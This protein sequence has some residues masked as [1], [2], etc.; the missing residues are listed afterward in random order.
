MRILFIDD[1]AE[2]VMSLIDC[3]EAKGVD[4]IGAINY[5]D[6]IKQLEISKF[7]VIVSDYN[8]ET[9]K[10]AVDVIEFVKAN[11]VRLGSPRVVVYSGQPAN[12]LERVLVSCGYSKATFACKPELAVLSQK[13]KSDAA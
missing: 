1:E 8:I 5:E 12:F 7:D 11:E 6:A 3:F 10:C 2:I 9:H 13:I 4:C